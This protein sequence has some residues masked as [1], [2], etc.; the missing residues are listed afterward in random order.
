M[1]KKNEMVILFQGDSI[2]D[3]GRLKDESRAWD[4]NHQM[5]HGYAFI[6]NAVLGAKYPEKHLKFI[7]KGISGNRVSDLY[8]RWVEDAL[9]IKPDVLSIMIGVNDCGSSIHRQ[10]GSDAKR[11]E[12]IYQLLIDEMKEVNPNVLIVLCEPFI[13]PVGERE[14]HWEEWMGVLAPLQEKTRLLAEK[15]NAVFV[16]L[17]QKFNELCAVREASYWVWDGVHPNISGHQI[18]AEEWMKAVMPHLTELREEL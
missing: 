18:V 1:D 11:F 6:I 2:T 3:G 17:Q 13:L 5:G 12:K 4:L 14:E 7:N 9:N 8:G 15:N 16:P 10:S